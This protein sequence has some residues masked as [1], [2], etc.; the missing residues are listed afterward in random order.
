MKARRKKFV[1]MFMSALV[2]CLFSLSTAYAAPA[3]AQKTTQQTTQQVKPATGAAATLLNPNAP[4]QGTITFNASSKNNVNASTWLTG[5]YQYIEWTCNGTH[6]NLVDVTLWKDNQKKVVIGTGVASGHTAYAVPWDTLVMAVGQYELRV[7]SEDDSRIEARLAVAVVATTLTIMTPKKDDF[8]YAGGTYQIAWQ[9]QGTPT[10]VN[11]S[12]WQLSANKDT[13][14]GTGITGGSMQYTV[15]LNF[16]PDQYYLTV[17][18]NSGP[19]LKGMQHLFVQLPTMSVT[20]PKAGDAWA[21]GNTYPI[22]WQFTGNPGPLKIELVNSS[23]SFIVADNVP[24]GT[25]GSGKYDWKVVGLTNATYQVKIT[26]QGIGS[27]TSS[28]PDVSIINPYV[29]YTWDGNVAPYAGYL[30][31]FTIKWKYFA[32]GDTIDITITDGRNSAIYYLTLKQYPIAGGQYVWIPPVPPDSYY[33]SRQYDVELT[34]SGGCR[35]YAS[36]YEYQ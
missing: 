34:T 35:G 7:T 10:S 21:P 31:P 8:W 4:P 28:S 26:S 1:Y 24:A 2:V 18:G 9:I 5:S 33:G 20:S 27:V 11:A 36:I 23:G 16:P 29:R 32:C 15:P 3:A 30:K 12:L 13:N 17:Y 25:G 6:S 14:I 19:G 22:T